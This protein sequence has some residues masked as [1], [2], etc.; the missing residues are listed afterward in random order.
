[1]IDS[2]AR[3][4][5]IMVSAVTGGMAN[6]A[7]ELNAV[8][9]IF[10]KGGLEELLFQPVRKA[11]W[12]PAEKFLESYL[13]QVVSSVSTIPASHIDIRTVTALSK[14]LDE[15]NRALVGHTKSME[16]IS[17]S[18]HSFARSLRIASALLL[19]TSLLWMGWSFV[20]VNRGKST[21]LAA[22]DQPR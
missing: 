6:L 12:K 20:R 22:L 21:D 13:K 3:R 8:R 19:F 5:G 7:K 18:I 11:L 15:M 2:V 17:R 1:V 16:Q 9:S 4:K 10:E 14:S